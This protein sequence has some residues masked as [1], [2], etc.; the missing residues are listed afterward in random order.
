M[1]VLV[2]VLLLGSC[3]SQSQSNSQNEITAR[4]IAR[5][6]K[7]VFKVGEPI[8]V[9]IRL[10]NSAPTESGKTPFYISKSLQQAGGGVAGFHAVIKD[11]NGRD[12]G[13]C[14]AGDVW[15]ADTPP[16]EQILR[17]SFFLLGS[18]AFV[19]KI[20]YL[21]CNLPS[22]PGR[23]IIQSYYSPQDYRVPRFSRNKNLDYPVLDRAIYSADISITLVGSSTPS[24]KSQPKAEISP[25]KARPKPRS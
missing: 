20:F 2:P 8:K 18:D 1:K 14:G 12:Y 23:Y 16:D 7:R 22:I 4:V 15:P 9:E 17:E 25:K 24:E 13:R 6:E 11:S 5:T 19:G 3:F 10:E 21:D